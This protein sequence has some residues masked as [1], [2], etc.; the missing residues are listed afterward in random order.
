VVAC[1]VDGL[2]APRASERLGIPEGTAKSRLI[3]AHSAL[4]SLWAESERTA[5]PAPFSPRK[6]VLRALDADV[7]GDRCNDAHPD[8]ARGPEIAPRS[9]KHGARSGRG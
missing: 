6:A 2:S 5:R 3:R 7:R 1:D 8:A 4:Q 9:R